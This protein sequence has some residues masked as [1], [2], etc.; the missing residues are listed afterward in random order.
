MV[1]AVKINVKSFDETTHTLVVQF[2]AQE[3]TGYYET[4]DFAF[5]TYNF[6]SSNLDDIVKELGTIGK[7]YIEQEKQKQILL[8]DQDLISKLKELKDIEVDTKDINPPMPVNNENI[9]DNLEVEI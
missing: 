3:G 6:K 8:N 2:S 9:I 4:S 7:A 1:D 5:Q